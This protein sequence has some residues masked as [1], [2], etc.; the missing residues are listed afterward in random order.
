MQGR[1][2]GLVAMFG[3]CWRFG[4]VRMR[5]GGGRR[6]HFETLVHIGRQIARLVGH[7]VDELVAQLREQREGRG[8]FEFGRRFLRELLLLLLLSS[9]GRRGGHARLQRDRLAR[10]RTTRSLALGTKHMGRKVFV[11][12]RR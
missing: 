6:C 2:H 5:R 12:R 8:R 11:D 9:E 7:V 10:A 1:V 3:L 4:A